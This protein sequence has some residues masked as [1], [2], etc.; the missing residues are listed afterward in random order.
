M[1][2]NPPIILGVNVRS[3][4]LNP[5]SVVEIQCCTCAQDTLIAELERMIRIS[6]RNHTIDHGQKIVETNFLDM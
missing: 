2:K 6:R 1:D 4:S 3:S 5:G